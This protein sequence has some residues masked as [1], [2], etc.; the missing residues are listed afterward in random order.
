[1]IGVSV[2]CSPQGTAAGAKC[3]PPKVGSSCSALGLPQ[4][5]TAKRS[6]ELLDLGGFPAK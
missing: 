2:L 3:S 1:M 6:S 5:G 4:E